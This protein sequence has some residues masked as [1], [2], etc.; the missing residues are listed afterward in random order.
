MLADL[1]NVLSRSSMTILQDFV[2]GAALIVM[3]V[4]VLN[5]PV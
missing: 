3:L 1:K 4:A 2:G 5:L